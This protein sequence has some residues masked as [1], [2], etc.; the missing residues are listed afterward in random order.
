MLIKNGVFLLSTHL[1]L[2]Y[3]IAQSKNL[4]YFRH[5]T[6][7]SNFESGLSQEISELARQL[8]LE[9]YLDFTESQKRSTD[10]PVCAI[11]TNC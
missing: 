5:V 3:N 9:K 4:K 6:F 2:K 11:L 10:N 1:L 7:W 8:G